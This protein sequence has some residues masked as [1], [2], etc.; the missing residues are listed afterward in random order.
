MGKLNKYANTPL[1]RDY[2]KKKDNPNWK[3][4]KRLTECCKQDIDHKVLNVKNEYD[5]SLIEDY[6]QR[7]LTK[8]SNT[9]CTTPVACKVCGRLLE[10]KSVLYDSKRRM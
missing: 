8:Y 5:W 3:K 1:D 2:F 4:E 7:H 10:Y 6:I 9:K